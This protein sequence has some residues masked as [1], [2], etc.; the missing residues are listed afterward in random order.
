MPNDGCLYTSWIVWL[1][2]LG[3]KWNWGE[4]AS[5]VE[6]S[7][8]ICERH[9]KNTGFFFSKGERARNGKKW[10]TRD[11]KRATPKPETAVLFSFSPQGSWSAFTLIGMH[12][13]KNFYGNRPLL[14]RGLI[15][16]HI[17]CL[18]STKTSSFF[19]PIHLSA[20]SGWWR[21][22]HQSSSIIPLSPT[23]HL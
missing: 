17:R 10:H 3:V 11:N 23:Y 9:T 15:I 6:G 1:K 7:T 20:S 19:T 22:H 8:S 12:G 18:V 16:Q 5:K 4:E 14:D 13:W 21:T 2:D